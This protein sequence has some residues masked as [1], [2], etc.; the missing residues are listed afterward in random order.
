[1][2]KQK[3]AM[4]TQIF[5][6]VAGF[7]RCFLFNACEQEVEAVVDLNISKSVMLS[8]SQMSYSL[9]CSFLTAGFVCLLCDWG[10]NITS[11]TFHPILSHHINSVPFSF[12]AFYDITLYST[13]LSLHC[14]YIQCH[15]T[16]LTHRHVLYHLKDFALFTIQE[17]KGI[18][19]DP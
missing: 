7:C 4:R 10:L 2:K 6:N 16:L 15:S 17:L 5:Q 18:P 1:M 13:T 11:F 9:W 19:Q 14:H 12:A 8:R 3:T